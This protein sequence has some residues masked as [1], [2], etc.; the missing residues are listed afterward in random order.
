MTIPIYYEVHHQTAR[1]DWSEVVTCPHCQLRSKGGVVARGH[2]RGVAPYGIGAESSRERAG[3][4]AFA[5]AVDSARVMLRRARCPRC[6]KRGS[7]VV[8]LAVKALLGW[9]ILAGIFAQ[10]A[11]ALDFSVSR[12][13]AC[14]A[15]VVL[16]LVS[17]TILAKLRAADA[18]VRFEPLLEGGASPAPPEAPE[19]PVAPAPSPR[20][21]VRAREPARE[22]EEA[23][24][25]APSSADPGS[26][27]LDLDRSWNKKG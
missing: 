23:P 7:G 10:A 4:D 1:L 21:P 9:A 22:R 25:P 24:G 8:W 3:I 15:A 19:A 12:T 11:I 2:G 26:L 18:R 13:L 14:A 5:T 27:E 16:L 6:G 20:R 17:L